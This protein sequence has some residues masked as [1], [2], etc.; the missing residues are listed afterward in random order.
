MALTV[1][2]DNFVVPPTT[3]LNAAVLV[4]ALT[5]S[6]FVPLIVELNVIE[7]FVE[8]KFVFATK[9]TA[10]PKLIGPVVVISPP[11]LLVLFTVIEE[12]LTV[13]PEAKVRESKT[14]ALNVKVDPAVATKSP[15]DGQLGQF[16]PPP[17]KL[18]LPIELTVFG[19]DSVP[20]EIV[21]LVAVKLSSVR[22]KSPLNVK[23]PEPDFTKVLLSFTKLLAHVT[24]WEFVS[25]LKFCDDELSN[26]DE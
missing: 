12:A 7:L 1:N 20:P 24:F 8:I 17:C 13:T 5:D 9:V 18:I 2:L 22:P 4:P 10:P 21:T 23:V 19:K 11:K 16:I 6:S 14:A 26:L 15:N 25:I 3:P